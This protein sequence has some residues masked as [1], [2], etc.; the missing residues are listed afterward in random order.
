MRIFF[1]M[2][3]ENMGLLH[4]SPTSI[5]LSLSTRF[6]PTLR[7]WNVLIAHGN[8]VLL[9]FNTSKQLLRPMLVDILMVFIIFLRIFSLKK[10]AHFIRPRTRRFISSVYRLKNSKN[11]F[12]DALLH[13]WIQLPKDFVSVL[14]LFPL[15]DFSFASLSSG[16]F[17]LYHHYVRCFQTIKIRLSFV[18]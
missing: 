9:T 2:P 7:L 14:S 16:V 12:Q 5:S 13:G 10:S 11:F 18:R 4:S 1:T 17:I 3:V 8:L 15:K 6:S